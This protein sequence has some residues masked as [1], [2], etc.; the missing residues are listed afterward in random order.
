MLKHYIEQRQ[1]CDPTG[2]SEAAVIGG[3]ALSAASAGVS[4][5]SSM[6]AA[7][8]QN[9]AANYNASVQEQLANQARK[10]GDIDAAAHTQQVNQLRGR[11]VAAYAGSG[12]VVNQ[13]SSLITD[14]QT[15]GYGELDA[16]TIK[17]NALNKAYGYQ[18]SA[19]IDRAGTTSSTNAL[20]T[21][22]LSSAPSVFGSALKA[23]A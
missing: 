10:Q 8:K 3:L 15:A 7:K 20:G 1:Y 22:L 13:D 19:N 14:T 6:Q 11:Q 16:L 17:N 2:I 18:V 9:D 5:Y 4:A 21:S 23:I 12:V